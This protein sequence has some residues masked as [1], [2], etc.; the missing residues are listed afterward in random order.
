[1]LSVQVHPSDDQ[2][3]SLEADPIGFGHGKTEA[4][5]VLAAGEHSRIYAG[6]EPGAEPDDLRALSAATLPQHVASFTPKAGDAVFVPGGTVHS[7]GGDLVVFEVQQN[8]DVTF[9]LF[10]WERVDPATGKRRDLQV[11]EAL[12]C[13]DTSVGVVA[14]VVPVVESTEPVLRERL[15]CCAQFGVWRLSG[16]SP[17]PVGVVG[18]PRVLV[19]IDGDAEIDD[20]GDRYRLRRGEVLVVPAVVGVCVVRPIGDVTVLELS[21]PEGGAQ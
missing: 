21:L 15:F 14:A 8:S 3:E 13:V 20:D 1:M 6:L 7:L 10:D 19:S 9:R 5:V 17:F 11:D 4:W 16:R 2:T 12:A 18:E